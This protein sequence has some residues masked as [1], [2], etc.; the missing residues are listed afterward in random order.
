[1]ASTNAAVSFDGSV[2]EEAEDDVSVYNEKVTNVSLNKEMD[3]FFKALAKG[4]AL[5]LPLI[6]KAI[7]NLAEHKNTT[8]AS[9]LYSRFV[10]RG[11]KEETIFALYIRAYFGDKVVKVS[12]TDNANMPYK[13]TADGFVKGVK[14]R[15]SYGLLVQALEEGKAFNSKTLIKKLR[16]ELSPKATPTEEA[17]KEAARK[18]VVAA[19]K[20]GARDHMTLAEIIAEATKAYNEAV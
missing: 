11:Q 5:G 13:I 6:H 1:M 20:K 2:F 12:K 4:E 17:A 16:E 8:P 19:A 15:N 18:A 9:A 7:V 14:P 3:A 10:A